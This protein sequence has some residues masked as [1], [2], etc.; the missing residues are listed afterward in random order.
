MWL[1]LIFTLVFSQDLT[2]RALGTDN[3]LSIFIRQKISQ[4]FWSCQFYGVT[5]TSCTSGVMKGLKL[6]SSQRVTHWQFITL[7]QERPIWAFSY[8]S[9]TFGKTHGSV[10]SCSSSL[11]LKYI[12]SN[13][14]LLLRFKIFF[15]SIYDI[16][17][18]DIS[19]NS[20][21]FSI[22]LNISKESFDISWQK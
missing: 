8:T 13:I 4:M 20:I 15:S 7:R 2:H 17:L 10:A 11:K 3:I 22:Q 12:S 5:I 18:H 21:D 14:T 19:W 6:D 9:P 16:D 1:L